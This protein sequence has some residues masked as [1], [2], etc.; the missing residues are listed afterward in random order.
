MFTCYIIQT[1]KRKYNH[2][3]KNFFIEFRKNVKKS[4]NVNMEKQ[5]QWYHGMIMYGIALAAV[6]CACIFQGCG[7]EETD[8]KKLKDLSYEIL[9]EKS[10]MPDEFIK[11][12][13]N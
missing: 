4:G 11:K 1:E 2:K 12:G 7:L 3:K 9:E 10:V 6:V 5:N 8:T 13:S